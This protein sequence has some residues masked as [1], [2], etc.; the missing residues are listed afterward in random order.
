MKRNNVLKKVKKLLSRTKEASERGAYYVIH[1]GIRIIY[2]WLTNPFWYYYYK[3]FIIKRKIPKF[4]FQ[5]DTY[6]YFF[7]N[8]N[9]T[10]KNERAIE[11][12][13]IWKIVKECRG[14]KILEVGNVLSHYFPVNHDILDKYEKVDGII[15]QDVV[16][17]QP[18]KKY[19]LIISI[20]T[21]EHVGWD[22]KPK[23]PMK[24][25]HAIENLKRCLAPGGKIVVTLPLGY[26]FEMDKLLQKG[27]IKFTKQYCLKRISKDNKW[28]KVDW[29]DIQS[30]KYD[31]PFPNA[32]GLV[33][34]I[35][36]K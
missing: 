22:E 25:L 9:T 10:W 18:S 35:I 31:D 20:S 33:I 26:N 27:K 1:S 34:G 6:S 21:L 12:P 4:T 8:Y 16:D 5:E 36:E 11:I 24:I 28:I 29:K 7:H 19:D 30:S 2:D 15:N 3:I 14:K 13:I 23:E 32:N 17:F